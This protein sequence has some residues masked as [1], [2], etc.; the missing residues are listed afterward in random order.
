MIHS[1]AR[2][3]ARGPGQ[4]ARVSDP[5]NT[6]VK[7]EIQA[8]AEAAQK[9]ESVMQASAGD[10]SVVRTQT[11]IETV[12][13]DTTRKGR[14]MEDKVKTKVKTKTK[15]EPSKLSQTNSKAIAMFRVGGITKSETKAVDDS[16]KNIKSYVK[17]NDKA[18]IGSKH[19]K[20][21]EVSIKSRA[22]G[23]C[24]TGIKSGDENEKDVCSWFWTGE[25][26]SV[27][28]WFWPEEEIPPQVYK[29]P[30]KI[31]EEPE[32]IHEPVLAIK[33]KAI[34]WSRP[35]Y[36]VLVPIEEGE[37]SLPP[38][39]NWTLVDTLIETPLGIRPLTKI[40]PYGG[41]YFQTLAE[42]KDQIREK[43]K[44]G[45]NPKACRCK[46]KTFSLEPEEFDKLVALLRLTRDPFIHQ[47]ATMI[48]GVTRAYPFTQDI[49]HDVGI[50]VMI[51]H[52]INSPDVKERPRALNMMRNDS[53]S[54]DE[55]I[56]AELY[57]QQLC[58][59]INS[60]Y[61]NSPLQLAGLKLLAQV[62]VEFEYHYII[63]NYI[64][65]LLL[66]LNRGNVKTKFY[67]L[68][69]FMCLSKNQAN[70][71][72]LISAEVL[73]SLLIPFNKNESKANI[74]NII[75][76][77]E[78]I[79]FHFKKRTKLFTKEK[80]TKNELFSIFQQTKV[81]HQKLLELS[82]H[83]D[84]EVRDKLIRLILKL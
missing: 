72:D 20:T 82:D 75:E 78:N 6:K 83:S 64:E 44:Y 13:M 7:A 77:F 1:G 19:E 32:P 61:L 25:E 2:A 33:Q 56:I 53:E 29:P 52:L 4:R 57:I 24:N 3:R 79:N 11:V 71:R 8:A 74:L 27:G 48:M 67:V 63:T 30:P 9:T 47:I 23:K 37:K 76:I 35:R 54:Y 31:E 16:E 39:G 59:D 34:A 45:P 43:E 69:V 12:A 46:S 65:D 50:T 18:N 22:K 42:I 41:P 62:S 26:S 15:A 36:I 68:K 17:A 58:K 55:S 73:S 80:F 10:G 70:T 51:E 28:S 66:F 21:E 49:V 38:E 5:A 84:P 81:L 14:K 40:P 60:F